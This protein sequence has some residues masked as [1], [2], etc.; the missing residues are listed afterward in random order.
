MAVEKDDGWLING[1]KTFVTNGLQAQRNRALRRNRSGR[2]QA[3]H[4][5]VHRR[6]GHAGPEHRQGRAQARHPRQQHDRAGLRRLPGSQGR[7]AGAA[8][9]GAEDRRWTRSTAA[10]SASRPRPSASPGRARVQPG[11]QQGARAVRS[12]NLELPGHSVEALQHG[13]EI[14]PP[15]GLCSTAAPGSSR[16]SSPTPPKLRWPRSSPA[17]PPAG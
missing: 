14:S 5:G 11:L 8:R 15:P 9:Q 12:A 10:G 4:V 16:T 17:R 6:E 2:S 7:A 13:R 3:A 1:A